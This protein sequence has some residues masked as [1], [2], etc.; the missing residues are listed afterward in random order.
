MKR[1]LQKRWTYMVGGLAL[2]CGLLLSTAGGLR[3]FAEERYQEL[4]L[5]AKV[6]NLVQQYYVEEVDTK[7][8]IYGGIKGMLR[9][10]DPHTNFLPPDIYKEFETETSGEF[11]G[12]GIE[13]TVQNSVLT[14]ISPIE[15]TPAWKAGVKAGDRIVEIDG[16]S[17]KG[18]SLV[19][20]AQRMKG[21]KGQKIRLGIFREGFDK[22]K[23]FVIERGTVKIKSVKYLDLEEGYGYVRITSFIEN[24]ASDLEKVLKAHDKKYKG[25]KGLIVDLRRN[26]GGLLDQA[27][28]I[29]DL[30]LEKGTIV[31]TMGRNQKEK[32]VIYAKKAG[33]L[34]NFP[35]IVLI[36]EYSA[37]ASEILAGALQDNKRALIMGQRSFGKGSVQSVVKL[38]DG[39]GLKLTVGRY[40]TPSGRSIQAY[41]IVPDIELEDFAPDVLDQARAKKDVHREKD[42]R[43]HL[44][45]DNED[46]DSGAGP[47]A[48]SEKAKSKKDAKKKEEVKKIQYWWTEA[49]SKTGKELTPKDKLLKDDFQVQQA[50]NYLKAWVVI[51]DQ[52]I[53]GPAAVSASAA[54][55]PEAQA[56]PAAKED[57]AKAVQP[58]KNEPAKAE[59]AKPES[60]KPEANKPESVKPEASKSE[61]KKDTVNK[62]KK[63]PAK[64]E[65]TQK[66][67]S[68][69]K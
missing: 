35:V 52:K 65:P 67:P 56:A 61:P 8:L 4:Q 36:D 43:G 60:K 57:A 23:E 53:P 1:I 31:S 15:D 59:P 66:D 20:A 14:V 16:E 3:A 22:P 42:M 25:T 2:G 44:I 19:E 50:Y 27:V 41:G 26:P 21:K 24:S 5:F 6:L 37:S 34:A 17:T 47:A 68:A 64:S 33:T 46:G 29:S 62:M 69:K 39:S 40:Y 49:E 45:G 28:Q 63:A 12:I 48:A 18:F 7:K 55:A 32:E 30:F 13:I 38:G 11:G 10:L 54:P 51:E 9:E 58:A